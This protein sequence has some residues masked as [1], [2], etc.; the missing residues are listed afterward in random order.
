MPLFVAANV[1]CDYFELR[2]S[3]IDYPLSLSATAR[4]TRRAHVG[5]RSEIEP[6]QQ[7]LTPRCH[8]VLA[9][10]FPDSVEL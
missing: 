4:R 7:R 9:I 5:T 8:R 1:N 6:K 3:S 10:K 2:L